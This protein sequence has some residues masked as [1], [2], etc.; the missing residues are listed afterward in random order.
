MNYLSYAVY[1]KEDNWMDYKSIVRAM[2]LNIRNNAVLFP[3][4]KTIVYVCQDGYNR[5]KDMW[6]R[7]Y[8]DDLAIIKV[9]PNTGVQCEMM[10]WRMRAVFIDDAEF[11]FCRDADSLCTYR[12]RQAMEEFMSE[13]D[14]TC[15]AITDSISHT[16]ALMG[17]LC[18]F[19]AS[20][21]RMKTGFNCW[22]D[23]LDVAET[24]NLKDK[25]GDQEFLN[26]KVLPKVYDSMTE[27]FLTGGPG[28]FR[29]Q[30]KRRVAD[31]E[32]DIP[33]EI[34]EHSNSL[35]FH[36]GQAGFPIEATLRFLKQH[37][38]K[39]VEI[40]AEAIEKKEPSIYYWY[41]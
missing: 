6:D 14:K 3:K 29:A 21:F 22:G 36:M 19:H 11:V 39:E 10:L 26:S 34:E 4:W 38:N 18:G 40:K 13:P 25:G 2:M 30:S 8:S 20:N 5:H 9:Y 17:G 28:Y 27:H 23:L 7:I 41:L 1:Y 15:H 33:K 35:V 37:G 12:E 32:L 16:I 24:F 31:I